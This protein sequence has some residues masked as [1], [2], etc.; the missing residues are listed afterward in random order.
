MSIHR[1]LMTGCAV[2]VLAFGLAA[3]GSSGNGTADAP[4]TGPVTMPEPMPY[5]MALT[6]IVAAD[7]AEA[8]QAAYDAVK[9]D[10]T[11]AQGEAL[12]EAV[13]SRTAALA[14]M[15][16][17]AMQMASLMTAAG[18]VGT[19]GLMTQAD[20]DA[21][22]TAIDALQTAID[23][24]ADVADTSMYQSQVDTA[25]MAVDTAQ[26]SLDTMGRMEMQRM[27]LMGA[28]TMAR[29]AVIGVSDD[30]TDSEVMAADYAVAALQA[31]IDAAED[32]PE[33]DADVASAQG[34]LDTLASTLASAKTSRMAVLDAA[35]EMQA[36]EMA[37]TGKALRAALAGPEATMNA[38][39][40]IAQHTLAAGDLTITA[41]EDAG[42]FTGNTTPPPAILKA[43]NNVAA[44]GSW[45]GTQYA[46]TADGTNVVNEAVVFNNKGGAKTVSFLLAGHTII[47]TG[48][49]K[50]YVLVVEAAL[51]NVM[52]SAFTHSG[53]ETHAIPERSKGF[54]T[55]GFYD[56][57]PGEY[58][59]SGDVACTSTNNGT[60]SPSG[61]VGTWHFKPDAGA[62]AMAQQPDA[63]Y[64]YYG[65]WV[66]KDKDGAPTAASAFASEV[67]DVD[68]TVGTISGTD[69]TGSATYAGNAAGKFAI[70]NVLESTG[71][72]GHF[73]AKA[74]LHA[75]FGMGAGVPDT[76]ITGTIDNF[77]L[78]DGSENPGW[79]VALHRAGWGAGG[80]INAPVNDTDTDVDE[81][82]GTTWSIDG[83]S[84]ARSGTW[85]GQMYD[86]AT[87]GPADDGSNLPTT[88]TGTFYSE[89]S[90]IGAHGRR[91][92]G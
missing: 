49:D 12:Q 53:T 59:C 50:G 23:A 63:N 30:S 4:T 62:N 38:L 22:Q 80:V 45:N 64:L 9:D 74:M 73:T 54:Y 57:A 14:T 43:G 66:S 55:R 75:K 11:A 1:K 61:L 13:D 71:D 44:R 81:L 60:G 16:R 42:T 5:E 36:A 91:L 26:D 46:H 3:C 27:A 41:A 33:G 18:G 69:L 10:V 77:R 7:T 34:T 8:A 89:F 76:G 87:T 37:K 70:N 92:R 68:G 82:M 2:A 51:M 17:A 83:N 88:V 19:S 52:A 25:E 84:A 6:G 72:G 35:R 65:W 39:N 31:A 40:N 85:S 67:G 86:E 28:V 20:I 21:A 90:T 56:G 78:N 15:A 32:L 58:R 47:P 29:T 24:A 79:S 48:D